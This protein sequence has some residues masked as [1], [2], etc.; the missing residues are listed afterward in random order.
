MVPNRY[1]YYSRFMDFHQQHIA[2]L[3]PVHDF[4]GQQNLLQTRRLRWV[5]WITFGFMAVEI[6]AGYAYG[7]MA[8]L[9]DGWHMG[10]HVAAFAV[11]LF[12]YQAAQ[13]FSAAGPYSFGGWK[14]TVLTGFASAVLLA[15]IAVSIFAESLW[16]VY[17]RPE[18]AYAEAF[19]VALL[20]LVVNLLCAVL[21]R[22][23]STAEIP[24]SCG[25]HHH[26]E[27]HHHE[28]KDWNLW[29]AYWHVLADGLTSVLAIAALGL[30]LVYGWWW[31]DPAVGVIGAAL[32]GFW[33]WSLMRETSGPL[34]DKTSYPLAAAIRQAIAALPDQHIADLHVWQI[35]PKN[36]AAVLSVVTHQPQ[37]PEF[38]KQKLGH[39]P[40]LGHV[41]VEINPFP[42][43][44][45]NV[46]RA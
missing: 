34:L 33:A 28:H 9:A 38:Y 22:P 8:L 23:Q 40:D 19:W 37:I 6:V 25:H 41:T 13:K 43:H 4:M 20:G 1:L 15:V 35:G 45:C 18:T 42:P 46:I 7:S 24:Q 26:H 36:F 17:T 21:L 27:H 29:G 12:G 32:I 31:A 16:H 44:V 39:L 3:T 5:L 11:A 10:S 14:F 2:R 30:G